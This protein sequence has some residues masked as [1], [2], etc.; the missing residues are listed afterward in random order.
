MPQGVYG[1][2]DATDIPYTTKLL[3]IP[4][5][6]WEADAACRNHPYPDMWFPERGEMAVH[7][8]AICGPCPVRLDCLDFALR[9]RIRDGVWGGASARERRTMKPR[10]RAAA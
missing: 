6:P 2:L 8:K 10:K 3:A 1:S 9:N 7:A 4:P 5:E